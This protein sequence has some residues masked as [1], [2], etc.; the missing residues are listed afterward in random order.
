MMSRCSVGAGVLV[1]QEGKGH[2]AALKRAFRLLV[3]DVDDQTPTD[4]AY[5]FS[6]HCPLTV[7]GYTCSYSGPVTSTSFHARAR[8]SCW[9]KCLTPSLPATLTCLTSAPATLVPEMTSEP[10]VASHTCTFGGMLCLCMLYT[11]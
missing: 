1:R 5:V 2:W 8:C 6:G 7:R 4:A 3:D 11:Q 10:P 9:C